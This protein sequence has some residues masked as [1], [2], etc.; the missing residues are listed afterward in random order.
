MYQHEFENNLQ[1]YN[2]PTEYDSLYE[3]YQDD[4]HYIQHYLSKCMLISYLHLE[5]DFIIIFDT[6]ECKF[7]HFRIKRLDLSLF[8]H[9]IMHL[10]H[11]T[12]SLCL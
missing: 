5:R 4:L 3:H 12:I 8:S 2:Y 11:L 10:H 1:K 7:S 9:L 6:V